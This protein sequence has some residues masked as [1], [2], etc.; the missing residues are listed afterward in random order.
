MIE[1]HPIEEVGDVLDF[2]QIVFGMIAVFGRGNQIFFNFKNP[3]N[4]FLYAGNSIAALE[5]FLRR[6]P[7]MRIRP[8]R[9]PADQIANQLTPLDLRAE[10]ASAVVL[11]FP[12][13][14]NLQFSTSVPAVS[15]KTAGQ[16]IYANLRYVSYDASGQPILGTAPVDGCRAVV[17]FATQPP[18]QPFQHGFNLHVDIVQQSPTGRRQLLPLL[19]DPIIRNP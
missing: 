8:M 1:Q 18:A 9:G 5:R 17:F 11:A 7:S 3:R 12:N 15:K 14:S 2:C 6:V 19:I 4:K 10:N 16:G 13:D